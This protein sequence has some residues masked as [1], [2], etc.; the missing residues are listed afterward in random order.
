MD[1]EF[2][3]VPS[4]DTGLREINCFLRK[5]YHDI[6]KDFQQLKSKLKDFKSLEDKSQIHGLS[7]ADTIVREK[8]TASDGLHFLSKES[9]EY[10]KVR[11]S[12][13]HVQFYFRNLQSPKSKLNVYQVLEKKKLKAFQEPYGSFQNQRQH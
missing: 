13:P 12:I 8:C 4:K 11:I 9:L 5:L 6:F 2:K 7:S 3:N 10:N 1:T